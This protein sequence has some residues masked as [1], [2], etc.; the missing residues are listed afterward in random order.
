MNDQ[1]NFV[2]SPFD[3]FRHEERVVLTQEDD[4]SATPVLNN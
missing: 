2:S 4:S 3:A 1:P